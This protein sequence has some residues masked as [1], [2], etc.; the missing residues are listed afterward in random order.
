[1][2]TFS[3]WIANGTETLAAESVDVS[4]FN[5]SPLQTIFDCNIYYTFPLQQI[6]RESVITIESNVNQLYLTLFILFH[7]N[8]SIGKVYLQKNLMQTNFFL[9]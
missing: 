5:H 2:N 7:P 3:V 9:N 1:M 8:K 6:N 4:H